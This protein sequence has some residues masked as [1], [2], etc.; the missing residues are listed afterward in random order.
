MKVKMFLVSVAI[1]SIALLCSAPAVIA[2][3]TIKIGEMI[4]I[5]L[6]AN[7]DSIIQPP[8]YV[9]PCRRD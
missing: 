5:D 6:L 8:L 2:G 1:V 4:F 7:R 3:D 9:N